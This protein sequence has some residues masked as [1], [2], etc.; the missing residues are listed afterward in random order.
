MQRNTQSFIHTNIAIRPL[1][2]LAFGFIILTGCAYTTHSLRSF[3]TPD[4]API[5]AEEGMRCPNLMF[6]DE[7]GQ[8][9]ELQNYR[10]KIVFLNF[11]ASWCIP[12]QR[13]MPSIQKLYDA[14][15][16]DEGIEFI[17]LTIK[18]DFDVSKQYA[19]SLGYSL[20]L[21]KATPPDDRPILKIASIP[22]TLILDRNGII[23]MSKAGEQPWNYWLERVQDL[24]RTSAVT[25]GRHYRFPVDGVR[26][27]VEVVD[28]KPNSSLR[29]ALVPENGVKLSS[30]RGIVVSPGEKSSVRWVTPMP[31]SQI[32]EDT[33]YFLDTP[34]LALSF[35]SSANSGVVDLIIEYGYCKANSEECVPA[36]TVIEVPIS[37]LGST[38]L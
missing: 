17:L 9:K 8:G 15:K 31:V 12:C 38:S 33:D 23:V 11:W 21:Y 27:E 37:G 34:K 10:G 35:I 5:G 2:F 24:I 26:I 28:G 20:P 13:E 19:K 18:K 7:Q 4:T 14:L 36:K 6:Q 29:L 16:N 30:K 25:S 22:R 3:P 32:E 1:L